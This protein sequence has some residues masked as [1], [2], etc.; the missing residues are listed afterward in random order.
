[1]AIIVRFHNSGKY[2]T[3][4]A[5]VSYMLLGLCFIELVVWPIKFLNGFNQNEK[6][7]H[8]FQ[9]F[10]AVLTTIEILGSRSRLYFTH[11]IPSETETTRQIHGKV[12]GMTFHMLNIRVNVCT[13]SFMELSTLCYIRINSSVLHRQTHKHKQRIK[14]TTLFLILLPS[15]Q[16]LTTS[17]TEVSYTLFNWKKN[18]YE[19]Y[20]WWHQKLIECHNRLKQRC[21]DVQCFWHFQINDV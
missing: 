17:I 16:T 13:E 14:N 18:P 19:T 5:T 12:S 1:M 8:K 10:L 11:V 20:Q 15:W 6:C 3:R 9:F 7:N 4:W 2:S 21:E